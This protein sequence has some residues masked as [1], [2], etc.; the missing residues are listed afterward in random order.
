MDRDA[1]QMMLRQTQALNRIAD[2]CEHLN[3]NLTKININLVQIGQNMKEDRA[4]GGT[5]NDE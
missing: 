2:A 5:S 1:K 4:H 3:R